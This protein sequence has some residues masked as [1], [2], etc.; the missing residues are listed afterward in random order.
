MTIHRTLLK[1]LALAGACAMALPL[2]VHA[3]TADEEIT[4]MGRYGRVP[5]S[6]QSLSQPVSYSDLDLS[7]K[8][9]RDILRHR[10]A[11]TARYLCEKLGET[12]TSSGPVVPSC[13]DA[14][15]ND[16]MNRVGTIEAHFAPRGSTWV[17]GTAWAPPYP[18]DWDSRY[19]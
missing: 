4:V 3:Q 1:S 7:T 9:G 18:S 13:R 14:A 19:P 2:P 17:A 11:L 16:A 10:V 15:V 6:V 12:D 8:A 5:D